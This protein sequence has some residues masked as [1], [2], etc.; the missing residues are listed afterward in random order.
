[1][2]KIGARIPGGPAEGNKVQ[3]DRVRV[4]SVKGCGCEQPT[5][6][7]AGCTQHQ[8]IFPPEHSWVDR[9]EAR[10]ARGLVEQ[11]QWQQFRSAPSFQ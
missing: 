1:M 8:K 4:G 3:G 7:R 10:S 2:E 6:A 11:Q 9:S 5:D